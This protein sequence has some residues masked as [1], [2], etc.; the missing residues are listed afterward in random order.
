M[1]QIHSLAAADLFPL[2]DR[3]PGER[4]RRFRDAAEP[5]AQEVGEKRIRLHPHGG[6]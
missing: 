1:L 3:F 6:R 4:V 2:S 5:G